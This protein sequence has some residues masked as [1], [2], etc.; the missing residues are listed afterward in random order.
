MK[1]HRVELAEVREFLDQIEI[2]IATTTYPHPK[3]LSVHFWGSDIM[4]RSFKV[5]SQSGEM[6]Y[7]DL[8]EAIDA[9]ND[10]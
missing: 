8:G 2:Q 9:Y 4:H 5:K 7:E 10:A 3:R 6:T 1:H